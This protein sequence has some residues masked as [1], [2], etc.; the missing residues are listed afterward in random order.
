MAKRL[1]G[2]FEAKP[3]ASINMT[4]MVPVLLALFAVIAVASGIGPSRSVPL[5]TEPVDP[6]LCDVCAPEPHQ[7]SLASGGE[8]RFDQRPVSLDE[9]RRLL[10]TGDRRSP[11]VLF[12]ADADVSYALAFEVVQA[13]EHAGFKVRMINED[14]H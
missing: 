11:E 4:P 10:R 8:L 12:R 9:A 2:R 5:A 6:A 1:A 13:V 14:L 7:V 3:M